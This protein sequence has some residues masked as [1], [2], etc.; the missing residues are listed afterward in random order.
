MDTITPCPNCGGRTL[1]RSVPVN[2][3][4]GSSPD[5]L[6]GLG[7]AFSAGKFR[8]VLCGGCGLT[9]FFAQREALEKVAGSKKWEPVHPVR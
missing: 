2:A 3:G 7:R 8:L 9:R 6:P 4:D 1:F 5:Y